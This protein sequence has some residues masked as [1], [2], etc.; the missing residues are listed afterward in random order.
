MNN[1]TFEIA[2]LKPD[3]TVGVVH[4]F[5]AGDE[6]KMQAKFDQYLIDKVIIR[7]EN[8]GIYIFNIDEYIRMTENP[9]VLKWIHHLQTLLD[10]RHKTALTIHQDKII[11]YY[12]V[13]Y[14]VLN[15]DRKSDQDFLFIPKFLKG[16]CRF[17]NQPP[18]GVYFVRKAAP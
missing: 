5:V 2:L 8:C 9:E 16:G 13:G 14:Y 4:R 15:L 12:G 11:D 18:D 7:K 6:E 10:K 1:N 3:S 17:W